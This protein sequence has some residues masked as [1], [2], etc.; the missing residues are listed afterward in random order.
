[1][2]TKLFFPSLLSITLAL[3]GCSSGDS[4]GSPEDGETGSTGDAVEA[5]TAKRT[6]TPATEP[7]RITT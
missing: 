5:T 2:H 7:N 3:C 4:D 6:S 1:M